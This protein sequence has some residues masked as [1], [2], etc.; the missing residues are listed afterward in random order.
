MW[1]KLPEE[2]VQA[3]TVSVFKA[4]LDSHWLE[5]EYGHCESPTT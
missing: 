1:N 3:P 2:V 5:I 4:R